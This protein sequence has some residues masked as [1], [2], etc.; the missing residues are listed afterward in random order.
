MSQTKTMHGDTT[1]TVDYDSDV[2]TL[3]VLAYYVGMWSL[4]VRLSDLCDHSL[5][6]HN[7][8][9]SVAC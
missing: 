5:I 8:H 9:K 7:C 1:D 2:N 6:T 4:I 3:L